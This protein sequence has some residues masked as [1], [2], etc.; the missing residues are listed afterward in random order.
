MFTFTNSPA[1]PISNDEN[2]HIWTIKMKFVLRSCLHAVL[3]DHIF[4]KIMDLETC[5]QV[6]D[7]GYCELN[8]T[9]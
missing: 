9:F 3:V 4:T 6:W 5:K 8:A 7:N 2:Y 1:I